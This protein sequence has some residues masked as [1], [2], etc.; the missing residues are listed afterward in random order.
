MIALVQKYL[1]IMN[2]VDTAFTVA[3]VVYFIPNI[4]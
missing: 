1:Q 2:T 3:P 4:F